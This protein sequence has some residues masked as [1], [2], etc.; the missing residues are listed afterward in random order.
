MRTKTEK[1]LSWEGNSHVICPWKWP[2]TQPKLWSC[3]L[4]ASIAGGFQEQNSAKMPIYRLCRSRTRLWDQSAAS[5]KVKGKNRQLGEQNSS[6]P[7][8][9]YFVWVKLTLHSCVVFWPSGVY[10][11][12]SV[13]L[14][15]VLFTKSGKVCFCMVLKPQERKCLLCLSDKKGQ[16]FFWKYMGPAYLFIAYYWWA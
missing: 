13:L 11:C 12:R 16:R 14:V 9:K 4:C 3:L 6:P 10:F 15:Y 5:V 7:H 2:I 8:L 1:S